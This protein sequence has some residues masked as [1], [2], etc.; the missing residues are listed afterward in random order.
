MTLAS[1]FAGAD[2]LFLHDFTG[3]TGDLNGTAVETGTGSWVAASGFDANGDVNVTNAGAGSAT[4]AFTPTDGFVY[5]LEASFGSLTNSP[6]SQDWLAFGFAEGQS[7]ATSTNSRFIV[8]DVVGKAWTFQRGAGATANNTSFLGDGS[9][10]SNPGIVDGAAWTSAATTFGGNLALR[11]VLDTTGGAGNWTATW[12]ADTGSGFFQIR[13]TAVLLDET[14]D[15]VGF[16]ASNGPISGNIESFSLDRSNGGLDTTKPTLLST[17]PADDAVN[18]PT[19]QNL[20]ATFDEPIA[21]GAAGTITIRNLTTFVDTVISLPGPDPDGTLSVDG[22]ELTIT[23]ATALATGEEYSIEISPSAIEDLSGNAYDGLLTSSVPNWTFTTDDTAPMVTGMSP[24]ADAT[25]V[26]IGS[27]LTLDFDEDVEVGTGDVTIHL[28]SDDSV[29]T[30]IDVNSGLVSV[31]EGGVVIN[32]PADLANSTT[33][34]VNIPA[35]AFTDLSGISFAGISDTVTWRFTTAALDPDVLFADT[36][37]RPDGSDL[38]ASASGKSGS[39]GAL[40]WLETA[41]SANDPRILNNEIQIGEAGSGG[42]NWALAYVDHNFVD[43]VI[44]AAQTFTVSVDIVNDETGGFTRNAGIVVG[45]SETDFSGWT[46]GTPGGADFGIGYDGS[47]TEEF[48]I[49]ENGVVTTTTPLA[50]AN[51]DRLEV[52][53]TNVTDFDAGTTIDYEVFNNGISVASGDF[54]WS[55]TDENYIGLFSNWTND[56]AEFDNFEVR[57]PAGTSDPFTLWAE[58]GTLPGAVTFEGDLNEDG[59]QDGIAFLLG[60]GNPDDDA[61]SALPTVSE[62]GGGGLQMTFD[63]LAVADRGGAE[64]KVAYSNTLSG[65]TATTDV[66]PDENGTDTGGVVSYVVDTV[67]VDP[68]H[69][70]TATVDASVASGG[71]LFGRLIATP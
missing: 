53:F 1:S 11:V 28:A 56:G 46:A 35:G 63:C 57:A 20:V 61:N 65:W 51:P 47:G 29:I 5:T 39:L 55:G 32:P 64:L 26:T 22:A 8:G 16:A 62:N 38:N 45:G 19:S 30:S 27:D 14:I 17:N 7:P 31:T 13:G 58:S 71:K 4:L 25:E 54:V 49:F 23:P 42:G 36:F 3:D 12:F 48:R 50:F 43:S 10:G 21:L 67:T 18:V 44:T 40:D 59:V 60:V 69:R 9:A 33:Y 66:V 52:V 15:S 41:S 2:T 6:A 70:V 37:N 68:L 24:M 34:Y